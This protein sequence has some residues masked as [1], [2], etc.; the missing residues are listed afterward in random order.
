MGRGRL[1]DLDVRGKTRLQVSLMVEE[2]LMSLLAHADTQEGVQVRCRARRLIDTLSLEL[3]VPGD[4]FSFG[5]DSPRLDIDSDGDVRET[6]QDLILHSFGD[7]LRY[8]H[9]GGVNSVRIKAVRSPYGFLYQ[10][11]SSM[12]LA[13]ALGVCCRLLLP[14]DAITALNDN[15][16]TVVRDIF[17]NSLKIV[18]APIV[19]L[20]VATSVASF[21]DLSDVGR[22]GGRFLA[23]SLPL[24]IL[25]ALLAYATFLATG[26]FIA[27]ASV[28]VASLAQTAVQATDA[29]VSLRDTIVGIVPSNFIEP[30]VQTNVVQLLFLGVVAG[31]AIGAGSAHASQLADLMRGLNEL[32]S[33]MTRIFCR[34]IPLAVLCMVWS[35]TVTTGVRMLVSLAAISGIVVCGLVC[36]V[37]LDLVRLRLSGMAVRPFLARF[38]PAVVHVFSTTSTT[39]SL[40]ETVKATIGLGVSERIASLT[41]TLGTIFSKTGSVFYRV[42]ATLLVARLCGTTIDVGQAVSLIVC[43]LMVCISTP[44]VPGGAYIAF[45]IMLATVNA[46]SEALLCIVAIDAIMDLLVPV[47]N[48]IAAGVT[49]L[50]IAK[51]EGELRPV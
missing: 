28:D 29:T 50:R 12:V 19:F 25:V 24:E 23:S 45:Q 31:L 33:N 38:S 5:S 22:V 36:L 8:H 4:K 3:K 9:R 21:S 44:S 15:V 32:F 46:P 47:V 10:V 13:V 11:L 35:L 40:P 30:F 26:S 1:D 34:F 43:C 49:T 7:R 17:M 18:V 16:L 14:Q 39:V 42:L 6:L 41:L 37:C 48:V 20:S 51:Q 27:P 2:S